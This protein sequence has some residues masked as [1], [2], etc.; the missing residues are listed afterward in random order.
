MTEYRFLRFCRDE[1]DTIWSG[2]RRAFLLTVPGG[3]PAV[4]DGICPHRG[5][6]LGLGTY[7][8]RTKVLR[9]PWHGR[10]HPHR[11]LLT[12]AWPALRVGDHW[13]VALPP[14]AAGE[15]TLCFR[16]AGLRILPHAA[17]ET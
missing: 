16:R 4:I 7:D 11:F 1:A 9:C 15:A 10:L 6:P 3:M 13:L 2:D 14:A 8:C 5:G 12:R 17:G